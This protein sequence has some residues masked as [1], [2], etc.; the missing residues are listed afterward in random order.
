M[1]QQQQQQSAYAQP[2]SSAYGSSAFANKVDSVERGTQQLSSRL[3]A[4]RSALVT[5]VGV[6]DTYAG[7]SLLYG[8][9]SAPAF[10]HAP[11]SIA[12]IRPRGVL[13]A[14]P[15]TPV[16]S[17]QLTAPGSSSVSGSLG[18]FM[19]PDAYLGSVNKRLVIT[20]STA[21]RYNGDVIQPV[22]AQPV[23]VPTDE[24]SQST[25]ITIERDNTAA[26]SA[27]ADSRR[28][29][30]ASSSVNAKERQRTSDRESSDADDSDI[31][32]DIG[33]SDGRA[34]D[35]EVS[36]APTL[37]NPR[38]TTIPALNELNR[39][40]AEQLSHVENFTIYTK[41]GKIQWLVPVDLR[42]ADLDTIV[43]IEHKSAAVYDEL[44]DDITKPPVG[45][46]LNQ[47][48]QIS[49][50]DVWPPRSGSDD[51]VERY[52]NKLERKTA[53]MDA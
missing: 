47:P 10:S 4:D 40:S 18:G 9:T 26:S 53:Q 32:G 24:Q 37:K 13:L 52:K 41:H 22:E 12:R 31:E 11:R 1:Q 44:P 21:K 20:P 17:R 23:E 19:T 35:E 39:M 34:A 36:S 38:Y 2:G 45:S 33:S 46:G 42:H 51:A 48:A 6:P 49:L 7:S 8:R 50:H 5:A 3:D 25:P 14:P 16:T 29:E 15:A 27:R 28:T 30:P 43:A